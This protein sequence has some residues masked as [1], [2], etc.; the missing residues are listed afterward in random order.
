[1]AVKTV[2]ATISWINANTELLPLKSENLKN[3]I[4]NKDVLFFTKSVYNFFFFNLKKV[5]LRHVETFL[6]Y[7]GVYIIFIRRIRVK[8]ETILRFSRY[9]VL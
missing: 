7:D 8:N 2:I 3:M 6:S 9:Y 1:M 5:R 4:K